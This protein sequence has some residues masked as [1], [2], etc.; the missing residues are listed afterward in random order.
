M[1]GKFREIFIVGLD[2]EIKSGNIKVSD[3]DLLR[4]DISKRRWNV[5]N[6]YP[7]LQTGLIENY[8]ARYINR[9]AISKNRLKYSA[10][11]AKFLE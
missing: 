6:S 10:A 11:G 1:C 5:R 7:T 3:Y 9:V 2:K 4:E 8:L